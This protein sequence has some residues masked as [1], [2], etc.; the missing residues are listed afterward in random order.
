MNASFFTADRGTHFK[1]GALAVVCC[2]AFVAVALNGQTRADDHAEARQA[3]P[4]A[5]AVI[6]PVAIRRAADARTSRMA[7]IV[8]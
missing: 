6:H 2:L 4:P 5:V 7:A 8:D 3:S 1:I